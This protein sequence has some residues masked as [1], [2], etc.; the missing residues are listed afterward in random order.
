MIRQMAYFICVG[1]EI[2]R[3]CIYRI[4]RRCNDEL[5][6]GCCWIMEGE[7][8]CRLSWAAQHCNIV[9]LHPDWFFSKS[10]RIVSSDLPILLISSM[11]ILLSLAILLQC[12]SSF[13]PRTIRNCM[14]WFTKFTWYNYKVFFCV[15]SFS[16]WVTWLVADVAMASCIC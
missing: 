15:L 3:L 12:F 7:V 6:D 10:F 16:N 13:Y 4:L 14:K 8:E 1:Q 2:T 5:L 11:T 9:I